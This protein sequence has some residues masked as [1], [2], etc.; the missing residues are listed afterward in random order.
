[1]FFIAALSEEVSW[2]NLIDP[3]KDRWNGLQAW[4]GHQRT[5]HQEEVKSG[6]RCRFAMDVQK[7][8]PK[9]CGGNAEPRVGDRRIGGLWPNLLVTLEVR[10][11]RTGRLISFPLVMVDYQGERYLVAMLGEGTNWVSNV[12]EAGG[13]AGPLPWLR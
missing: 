4:R 10:G 7:R 11:R 12:R 8:P 1:V 9:S 2:S 6:E 5:C 3:C 13:Q